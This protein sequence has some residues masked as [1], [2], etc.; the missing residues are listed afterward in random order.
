[1]QNKRGGGGGEEREREKVHGE[2]RVKEISAPKIF[3]AKKKE[4][5]EKEKKILSNGFRETNSLFPP[6]NAFHPFAILNLY[7]SP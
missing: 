1:M 7:F 6:L 4:K 2:R 3:G 5:K